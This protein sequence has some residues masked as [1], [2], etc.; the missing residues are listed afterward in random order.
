[1]EK[2]N[3]LGMI[4]G[5]VSLALFGL[6][7]GL[8]IGLTIINIFT[9]ITM[10]LTGLSL[11]AFAFFNRKELFSFFTRSRSVTGVFKI[12]Q[13]AIVLAILIFLYLISD[14]LAWKIDLTASSLYSLSEQTADVLKSVTNEM[15][16]LLFKSK[17]DNQEVFQYQENLLKTY[18]ERNKFIKLEIVDYF[19]N[20]VKADDYGIKDNKDAGLAVF[21]YNGN[22]I[23]V[24]IEEIYQAG[25]SKGVAL[26]GEKAY[27][28]AIKSLLISK[29]QVA[30]FLIGHGEVN[31]DAQ[32]YAGYS[33]IVKRM[34]DEKVQLGKL[35][36]M[37]SPVIPDDC[38]ILIIGQPVKNI[39]QDEL[40]KVNNYLNR[41]GSVL[42]L[43]DFGID[44][45]INQIMQTMGL[46]IVINNLV[47]EN[48]ENSD[49]LGPYAFVPNV[50]YQKEITLPLLKHRQ[51]VMFAS[52]I[53]IQELDADMRNAKF[54]YNIQ[55]LLKTTENSY[56]ETTP[57]QIGSGRSVRDDK[58]IP[59][60]LFTAF[61]SAR[62]QTS[63]FTNLDKIYTNTV[64]ARMVVFGDVDFVK[65]VYTEKGGNVD[66]FM[67]SL[68]YLLKRE[69]NVSILPKT[70]LNK[71]LVL[72]SVPKRILEIISVFTLLAYIGTGIFIVVMR[73]RRIK[74]EKKETVKTE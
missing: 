68:N 16:I 36:L 73:R 50:L 59:G 3:R 6:S 22:R 58:D 14:V 40:D 11:A 48:Q 60:P 31:W 54:G 39:S 71:E 20:P 43:A 28:A 9:Q 41:G 38:G 8:Y 1:M 47:I 61:A 17:E 35:D 52:G 33:E 46:F 63:I 2:K 12:L 56:A 45:M 70:V 34:R 51:N 42:I 67:N 44:F 29:E 7:I 74:E 32:D 72:Q 69:A 21:E 13:F 18:A 37:K 57:D 27:T 26:M 62:V 5:I 49:Q 24:K 25:Q 53:A 10:I 4:L 19:L 65:N 30:Y 23:A 15:K 66:L 64:E 55:P